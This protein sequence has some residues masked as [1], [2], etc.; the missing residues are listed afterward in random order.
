VEGE[1]GVRVAGKSISPRNKETILS[2]FGNCFLGFYLRRLNPY[3][4]IDDENATLGCC[5][6]LGQKLGFKSFHFYPKTTIIKFILLTA[7]RIV[8]FA[9][10]IRDPHVYECAMRVAKPFFEPLLMEFLDTYAI[11]VV[12]SILVVAGSIMFLG[13][14]YLSDCTQSSG[15]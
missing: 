11:L 2:H 12:K 7:L 4:S 9:I 15:S 6:F 5:A 13:F 1:R 8:L 10:G 14:A 3:F